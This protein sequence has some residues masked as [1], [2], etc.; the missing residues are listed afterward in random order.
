[1]A[2]NTNHAAGIVERV[3]DAD[4]RVFKA[5]LQRR[6]AGGKTVLLAKTDDYTIAVAFDFCQAL[7]DLLAEFGANGFILTRRLGGAPLGFCQTLVLAFDNNLAGDLASDFIYALS[8]FKCLLGDTSASAETGVTGLTA[9]CGV[10]N[11]LDDN[12]FA[13]DANH[14]LALFDLILHGLQYL[15]VLGLNVRWRLVQ[16]CHLFD[17]ASG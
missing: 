8:D 11:N 6:A 2:L 9:I 7:F 13:L 12:F 5:R 1:M 17:V 4:E 10:F 14:H 16:V 3:A 15:L